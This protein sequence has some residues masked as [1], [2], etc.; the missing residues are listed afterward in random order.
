MQLLHHGQHPLPIRR[1][2]IGMVVQHAGNGAEG[3]A[4]EDV[5]VDIHEVGGRAV[6]DQVENLR[7]M[8]N[9]L[10]LRYNP[11]SKPEGM[12]ANNLLDLTPYYESGALDLKNVDEKYLDMCYYQGGMYAVPTGVNVP[13]YLYDPAAVQAIND[14]A[15]AFTI[16]KYE[17]KRFNRECYSI[18]WADADLT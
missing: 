2:D 11:W 1:A 7:G 6:P 13:I 3:D 16:Y 8:G 5:V 17:Q 12:E 4:L 18:R 15:V 10:M 14:G 9:K